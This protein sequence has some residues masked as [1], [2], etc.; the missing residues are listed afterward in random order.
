M[1]RL[2]KVTKNFKDKKGHTV[3]A[4]S[5][6]TLS[7]EDKGLTAILGASG[8]GKTTLLSL[9]GGVDT[10]FDG[11]ILIDGKSLHTLSGTELDGY[12]RDQ[13]G[14]IFQSYNLIPQET[15][16]GNLELALGITG[17][18]G[19]E[20]TAA[21][22]KALSDLGLGEELFH[23]L[24]SQ[25]S[26]GE[27]QRVAIARA[28]A[29]PT[30][31]LLADEPTGALDELCAEEIMSILSTAAKTKTVI[32][33]THNTALA[34]KYADRIVY[35]DKGKIKKISENIKPKEFEVTPPRESLIS[36]NTDILH[37]LTSEDKQ[38]TGYNSPQSKSERKPRSKRKK[39]RGIGLI[40]AARL[41]LKNLV[42]KKLR[43]ALVSF[44]SA[45]AILGLAT[46]M[47]LSAGIGAFV[48]ALEG[49]ITSANPITVANTTYN[50]DKL[51]DYLNGA[52]GGFGVGDAMSGDI[53]VGSIAELVTDDGTLSIQN[54]LTEKYFKYLELMPEEYYGAKRVKYGMDL[55]INIYTD[56]ISGV[57]DSARRLSLSAI[58]TV[59][60]DIVKDGASGGYGNFLSS[61][62]PSVMLLP[63]GE[64][65]ILDQ[66]DLVGS[67][68]EGRD[69]LVLV[70]DSSGTV[71]DMNLAF[72]GYISAE[73]LIRN[74]TATA[75]GGEPIITSVTKEQL[76]DESK[77]FTFYP[78]NTVFTEKSD[79]LGLSPFDYAYSAEG[80][81]EVGA[82]T[83][84]IT[85]ILTPKE[86][87]IYGALP[88]GIYYTSELE[89]YAK[90]INNNSEIAKFLRTTDLGE[91]TSAYSELHGENVGI[92]YNFS[93]IHPTLG[94]E[95]SGICYM[96]ARNS[97][98]P[99]ISGILSSVSDATNTITLTSVGGARLPSEVQYYPTDF[100]SKE[101]ITD[102]LDRWNSDE[103]IRI[104]SI[105]YTPKE[106]Q[107][108]LFSDNSQAI[109]YIIKL[110]ADR[111]T[112]ALFIATS[113]ALIVSS[114]MI[115]LIIYVSVGERAKEIAIL[116]SL[117][118]SKGNIAALFLWEGFI[119]G[120]LGSAAGLALAR[121]ATSLINSVFSS[122]V[123]LLGMNM[124]TF[125]L[126]TAMISL[127]LGTLLALA[128]ALIP[129]LLAAK[130]LAK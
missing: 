113:L 93:Y 55:S 106:R 50:L 105:E 88:A 82:V 56:F 112:S 85:G 74:V 32:L 36:D 25:L 47:A 87:V 79:P 129:S 78:N 29:K 120:I 97:D 8:C 66:Y 48:D 45:V 109:M 18:S 22:R 117:G 17:M 122:G 110:L 126:P 38:N 115:S 49:D 101:R 100:E 71:S 61:I 103:N 33:V 37:P 81:S 13:V 121:I 62:Y 1:L 89:E 41:S 5:D 26:G 35:L 27:Q 75:S 111:V 80:L 63:D 46:V 123:G 64:E 124:A 31:I 96:D 42:S 28:L 11:K 21:A 73:E 92:Y 58:A 40:R 94:T 102:Y 83:L 15:A 51:T 91:I 10:C 98:N 67:M 128:C 52:I 14:F 3:T 76:L 4:L 114:V 43:T 127:A 60:D 72:Y 39:P 30:R 6:I 54:K 24:P 2:E 57:G 70:L 116:R 9:I 12:R 23:K 95:K 16:L 130:K 19:E 59:Y 119:I 68:P 34:E 125:T 99:L 20:A 90:E 104:G 107:K 65:Y 77:T 84:R 118:A 7:F 53:N 108:V 44:G 86:N 69:E